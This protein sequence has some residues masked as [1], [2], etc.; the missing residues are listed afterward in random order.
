M[1]E[2]VFQVPGEPQGKERPRFVR[3]GRHVR[4]YTPAKTHHYEDMVRYYAKHARESSK[5]AEPITE[6]CS[7]KINAYFSVPKSYTKKR[8]Q[9]CLTGKERPSKKP[10]SDNIAKIVLDGLNPKTK[11]DK[12]QHQYVV[13]QEGLFKDDKQVVSLNVEKW[14]AEKP[15]IEVAITWNS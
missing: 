9:L 13:V 1:T 6:M 5:L 11:L 14:Y 7:I 12:A 8:T 3:G 2:L 10:D 4:T 15:R